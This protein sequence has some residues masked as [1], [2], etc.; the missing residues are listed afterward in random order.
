MTQPQGPLDSPTANSVITVVL[1]FEKDGDS[2]QVSWVNTIK[3]DGFFKKPSKE[4]P[5]LENQ[6]KAQ[7]FDQHKNLIQ[8]IP[9]P[10]LFHQSLE[11]VDE[12]GSFQRAEVDL[13]EAYYALRL[14]YQP[15]MHLLK[16]FHLPKSRK[17]IFSHKLKNP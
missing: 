12:E 13:K 9:I 15:Q 8:E 17:A 5:I 10:P 11:Y 16:V 2:Y 14:H 6:L 3:K 7:V 1:K 4:L